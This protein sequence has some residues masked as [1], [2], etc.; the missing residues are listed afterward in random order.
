MPNIRQYTLRL[1]TLWSGRRALTVLVMANNGG[2][3]KKSSSV[4][5]IQLYVV[6]A[7]ASNISPTV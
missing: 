7:V 6:S 3:R 5:R 4:A 1:F 2:S